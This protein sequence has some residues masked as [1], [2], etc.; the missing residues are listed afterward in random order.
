[1]ISMAQV[2]DGELAVHCCPNDVV[3]IKLIGRLMIILTSFN[4]GKIWRLGGVRE[5]VAGMLRGGERR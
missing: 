4:A 5:T 2:L 1:M 3:T